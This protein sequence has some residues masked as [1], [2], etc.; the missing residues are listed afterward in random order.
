MCIMRNSICVGF[1]W[2]IKNLS[3]CVYSYW[4]TFISF[5]VTGYNST[6]RELGLTELTDLLSWPG[7]ELRS[8]GSIFQLCPASTQSKKN[9]KK[10]Q[11]PYNCLQLCI[12]KVLYSRDG[13]SAP[14]RSNTLS[15]TRI[16]NSKKLEHFFHT[17]R[18]WPANLFKKVPFLENQK[19]TKSIF[20]VIFDFLGV[21]WN[22]V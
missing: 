14:K 3:L 11:K 18:A 21:I 7:L 22:N 15:R 20:Y 1:C 13:F 4:F 19:S 17:M 2:C 9:K 16:Y 12:L 8:N 10:A 6:L 5:V